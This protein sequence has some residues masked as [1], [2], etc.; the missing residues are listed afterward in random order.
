MSEFDDVI[1]YGAAV[2]SPGTE[3]TWYS[4]DMAREYVARFDTDGVSYAH[5]WVERRN[6][7]GYFKP[8]CRVS[9]PVGV[10]MVAAFNAWRET[11]TGWAGDG[12]SCAAAGVG[13]PLPVGTGAPSAEA[14][15][16]VSPWIDWAGT[17]ATTGG[18][19]HFGALLVTYPD[20]HHVMV[21]HERVPDWRG[22]PRYT[23]RAYA[24]PT[25]PLTGWL[26][27]FDQW[28]ARHTGYAPE[29]APAVAGVAG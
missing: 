1:T 17:D 25:L 23:W 9:L 4:A 14:A 19:R 10:G 5:A 22:E 16:V 7:F 24:T 8:M 29:A 18:V 26:G 2:Q 6:G 11:E 20:R 27:L 13:A 28:R 12:G 21:V 3:F 15:R